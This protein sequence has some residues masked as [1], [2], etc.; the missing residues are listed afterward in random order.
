MK[1]RWDV[2]RNGLTRTG[3][4]LE[5]QRNVQGRALQGWS[6]SR[7]AETGVKSPKIDSNQL[8]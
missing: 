8:T 5:V 2:G 1:R 6:F 7:I 4:F 3:G